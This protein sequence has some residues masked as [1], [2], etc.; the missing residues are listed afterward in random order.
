MIKAVILFI[1]ISSTIAY[2]NNLSPDNLL[3]I[4]ADELIIDQTKQR[5]VYTGEVLICF[6]DIL[7]KT[8]KLEI[9]YKVHNQKKTISEI[10]IPVKLIA[11]RTV[12]EELL[13][14]DSAKYLVEKHELTLLGNVLI[15]DNER[16]IKTNKLVYFTKL[17]KFNLKNK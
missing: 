8:T 11:R 14:A 9:L 1:L 2:G 13:V 12:N 3:S 16:I 5:A 17:E 4:D 6:D 10:N 15:R 7:L